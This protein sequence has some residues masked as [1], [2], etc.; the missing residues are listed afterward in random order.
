MAVANGVCEVLAPYVV[1]VGVQEVLIA[2]T[3]L[4]LI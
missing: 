2:V 3:L 4:L 1:C